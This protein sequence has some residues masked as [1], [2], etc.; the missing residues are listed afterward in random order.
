MSKSTP[1]EKILAEIKELDE[2]SRQD[3]INK[4]KSLQSE[5]DMKAQTPTI[6]QLH[7]LGREIWKDVDISDYLHQERQWD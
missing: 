4:I 7:G 2:A 3:L 1:I 5:K 6:L